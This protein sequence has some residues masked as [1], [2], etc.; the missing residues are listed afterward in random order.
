M[1]LRL[2]REHCHDDA[3]KHRPLHDFK[4]PEHCV[5]QIAM[6]VLG[7]G[8]I[9]AVFNEERFPFHHDSGQT[10]LVRSKDG[11][12]T[13]SK[14]SLVLPWTEATGNWDCGIC[15][16]LDG[17]LLVNLTITGFSKREVKS[18]QPS[19]SSHPMTEEWGDW[20][21]AYKTQG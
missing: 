7:N 2:L 15:Q 3:Q 10:L 13:W 6:R 18:E 8:D 1:E 17:T 5:N 12:K 21:G 14:P 4:H 9:V 19:W 11:G 20:T 16:L